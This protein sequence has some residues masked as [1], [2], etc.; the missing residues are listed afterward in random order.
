[1]CFRNTNFKKNETTHSKKK[2]YEWCDQTDTQLLK[3][4]FRNINGLS[5]YCTNVT[6]VTMYCQ[7]FV[8]WGN[9]LFLQELKMKWYMI[10]ILYLSYS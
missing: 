9:Y 5:S 10:P 6:L 7:S 1:M 8:I 4:Y 3:E 2:S